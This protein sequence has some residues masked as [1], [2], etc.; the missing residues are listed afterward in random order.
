M[1]AADWAAASR[2][3]GA[4]F[5]VE[6]RHENRTLPKLR[7]QQ[8]VPER[9]GQCQR[10]LRT[11]PSAGAGEIISFGKVSYRRLP[12]LRS[13]QVFR[14]PRSDGETRRC[15]EVEASGRVCVSTNEVHPARLVRLSVPRLLRSGVGSLR[16][17]L[18]NN[19]QSKHFAAVRWH[20]GRIPHGLVSLIALQCQPRSSRS[21][22]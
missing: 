19:P 18:C 13:Y 9:R 8:P 22:Y 6:L 1:K 4:S 12:R 10:T 5:R 7:R 17:P 15:E 11:E 2:L 3:F 20:I 21:R 16:A 14:E